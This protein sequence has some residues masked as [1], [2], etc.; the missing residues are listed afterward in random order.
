MIIKS[1]FSETIYKLLR[2]PKSRLQYILNW[3]ST[4]YLAVIFLKSNPQQKALLEM[5]MSA[6]L[7]RMVGEET[8]INPRELKKPTIV[9]MVFSKLNRAIGSGAY[10]KD[11]KD[12]SYKRKRRNWR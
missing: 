11:M 2:L 6:R 12:I 1:Y 4:R 8:H 10:P 5:N 3:L 7:A 9:N